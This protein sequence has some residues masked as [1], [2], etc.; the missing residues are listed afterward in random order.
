[1]AR[2]ECPECETFVREVYDETVDYDELLR[3][4]ECPNCGCLWT[5]IYEL[6]MAEVVI[7]EHG[8]TA[9]EYGEPLLEEV[10]KEE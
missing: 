1:M 2:C 3:E 9:D 8:D 6:D 5:E 10:E 4:K 7:D